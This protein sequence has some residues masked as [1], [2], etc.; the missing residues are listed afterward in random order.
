MTRTGGS[1][2]YGSRTEA[3]EALVQRSDRDDLQLA[4]VHEEGG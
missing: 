1:K 2:V 3:R 4:D